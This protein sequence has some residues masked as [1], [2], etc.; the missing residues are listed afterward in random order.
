MNSREIVEEW[1]LEFLQLT[2]SIN[3]LSEVLELA[4]IV[5]KRGH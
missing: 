1:L 3:I 2:T 5:K 4:F